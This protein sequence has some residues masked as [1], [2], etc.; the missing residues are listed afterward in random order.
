MIHKKPRGRPKKKPRQYSDVFKKGILK[1]L[2]KMEKETGVSVYE[3][4]AHMLYNQ[5]I[6]DSVRASLW[7]ILAEVMVVK[8]S[9]QTVEQINYGP[10]IFLPE[11]QKRPEEFENIE[12]RA[13]EESLN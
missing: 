13:K 8:E 9:K 1:G 7:K 3:L 6:Q 11:V 2:K 12:K 10:A 4:F 5:K